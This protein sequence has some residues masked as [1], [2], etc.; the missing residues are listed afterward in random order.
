MEKTF[1]S[2]CAFCKFLGGQAS[3]QHVRSQQSSGRYHSVR[4]EGT[5]RLC[6]VVLRRSLNKV[7]NPFREDHE[8]QPILI[9]LL[10]CTSLQCTVVIKVS[11]CSY[12]KHNSLC[13]QLVTLLHHK[14]TVISHSLNWPIKCLFVWSTMQNPKIF[15]VLGHRTRQRTFRQFV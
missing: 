13:C 4:S 1:C 15:G 5:E 14:L 10:L 8:L 2:V 9:Y 6:N 3:L 7:R 11:Y 12:L